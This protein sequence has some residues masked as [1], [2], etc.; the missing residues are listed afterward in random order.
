MEKKIAI[1]LLLLDDHALFRES[2]VRFL[3]AEPP[4]PVLTGLPPKLI[5]TQGTSLVW[6]LIRISSGVSVLVNGGAPA[7]PIL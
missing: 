3:H 6:P 7:R 4:S 2:L 5:S 1:L